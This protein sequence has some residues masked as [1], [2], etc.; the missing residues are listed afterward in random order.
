MTHSLLE[1]LC[2][3]LFHEISMEEGVDGQGANVIIICSQI[4]DDCHQTHCI[5]VWARKFLCNHCW[6][7]TRCRSIVTKG[8]GRTMKM[9]WVSLKEYS[10]ADLGACSNASMGMLMSANTAGTTKEEL[11]NIGNT[12]TIGCAIQ[13]WYNNV[14]YRDGGKNT[15]CKRR[16]NNCGNLLI[17]TCHFCGCAF[18]IE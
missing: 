11:A 13:R 16:I 4:E 12:V 3:T 1:R 2:T 8:N 5:L 15:C 10:H 14:V 18:C 17:I 9:D 6:H 7:S